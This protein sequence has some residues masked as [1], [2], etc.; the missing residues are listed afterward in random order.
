MNKTALLSFFFLA[1]FINI[2]IAQNNPTGKP[3]IAVFAPLYLD[4]LFDASGNYKM[5]KS[6][7]GYSRQGIEFYQGVVMALDSLDKEG[8]SLDV[9]VFDT[10]GKNNIFKIADSGALEGVGLLLGAVSGSEYLDLAAIAKEKKIPFISAT[11]PNDGG[12]SGNPYVVVVNS[13][14]NTHIQAIYN[15]I[16]KSF[17]TDNIV[18]YRRQN[19]ADDRVS[20]VF[21]SLN[22]SSSGQVLNIHTVVLNNPPV[23]ADVAKSLD[24]DRQNIVICGSL[25]DNFGRTL[26]GI[27]SGLSNTYKITLV[28]MPTWESFV[29]LDRTDVKMPPVIYSTAFYNP[30][31]EENEWVDIF[32]GA[33]G[34]NTY[35]LPSE[36]AFRGYELTYL[37]GHM[38]NSFGD[39][40]M[41]NIDEKK[42]RL[43]TDF[44]FRPIRWSKNAVTAD[45]YENKRIY[46]VKKQT[47]ELTKI[48]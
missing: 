3:R 38:L 46:I 47:G 41:D 36:I 1:F 45:Y 48:N 42:F 23:A 4:T 17:G 24:K 15:Y 2:S 43:L 27:T 7:P 5:G 39:Q 28:G 20:G 33:Y 30:G 34:K 16:L 35:T 22:A 37:F 18:M 8:V 9:Q 31:R 10:K 21:K 25:D 6:I 40:L 12:I 26:L 29:E 13:K 11:Y 19:G 32:T 14:L 44:D